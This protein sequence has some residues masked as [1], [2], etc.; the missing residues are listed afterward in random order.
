MQNLLKDFSLVDIIIILIVAIPAIWKAIKAIINLFKNIAKRKEEL[1]AEIRSEIEDEY[2]TENRFEEGEERI[3]QLEKDEKSLEERV[4]KTEAQLELLTNSDMLKIR[5][6]IKKAHDKAMVMKY[7]DNED[8]GLLEEQFEV[9]QEEGG[10]SW[11]LKMMNDMRGLPTI[12]RVSDD[13]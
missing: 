11:A 8:L 10:N 4:K 1:A 12:S 7:I 6:D 5:R 3:T 9:Y 13:E 2:E